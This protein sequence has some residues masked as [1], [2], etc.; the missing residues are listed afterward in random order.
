MLQTT[1]DPEASY[2]TFWAGSL[3]AYGASS[4]INS[5]AYQWCGQLRVHE[6]VECA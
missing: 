3:D 5:S 4:F 6:L 2:H 1:D